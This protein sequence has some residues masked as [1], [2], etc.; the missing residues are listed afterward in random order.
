MT[1]LLGHVDFLAAWT[2]DLHPR[3]ADF[4]AHADRQCVLPLA[5]HPRTHP[6]GTLLVLVSHYGQTLRCYYVS[7]VDK[8]VDVGGLLVDGEVSGWRREYR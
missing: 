6:K 4:L 8:S 3:G 1:L 5:K 2:E 7:R